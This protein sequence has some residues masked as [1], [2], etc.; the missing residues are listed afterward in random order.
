MPDDAEAWPE[1][2][3]PGGGEGWPDGAEAWPDGAEA[4]HSEDDEARPPRK[5]A[6]NGSPLNVGSQKLGS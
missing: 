4:G 6:S 2:L 1:V 5:I 3:R